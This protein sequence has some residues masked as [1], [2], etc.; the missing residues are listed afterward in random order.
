[1]YENFAVVHEYPAALVQAFN[2]DCRSIEI[3]QKRFCEGFGVDGRIARS[4]NEII[5]YPC[6][7]ADI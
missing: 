4:Y 3:I 2:R 5:R 1:M 7:A 6:L